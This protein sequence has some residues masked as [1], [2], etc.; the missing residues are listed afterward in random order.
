MPQALAAQDVMD[1]FL[2]GH[3]T[4]QVMPDTSIRL[5]RLF[6]DPLCGVNQLLKVIEQDA[7]LSAR[8]IRSV[9]SAYYGLATKITNL[10]RAVVL[11]GLKAVKEV[12]LATSLIDAKNAVQIGDYSTADLW[13]HSLAVAVF[14]RELAVRTKQID[15]EDAFLAGMLHDLG[16]LF[17]AQ[18]EPEKFKMIIGFAAPGNKSF[19]E[20]EEPIF[21]FNHCQLGE[22]ISQRWEFPEDLMNTIRW[23][24]EPEQASD[25]HKAI[26]RHV[27][28]A[29]RQCCIAGIGFPLTCGKDAVG[30]DVLASVQLSRE[31]VDELTGRIQVLLRLHRG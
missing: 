27:H 9:N 25:E 31:A 14:A 13:E 22:R 21:H 5:M 7:A 3:N 11:M 29:D 17:E 12:T 4:I 2:K 8:I 10:Q 23:H 19:M 28:I 20:L 24:H 16:L 1:V 30:D 26:C 15:P 6:R 18:S